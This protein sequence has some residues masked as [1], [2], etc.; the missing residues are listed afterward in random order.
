MYPENINSGILK[1]SRSLL[2]FKDD[3]T[4]INNTQ[5]NQEYIQLKI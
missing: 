5:K 4:E 1:N 3:F 2:D